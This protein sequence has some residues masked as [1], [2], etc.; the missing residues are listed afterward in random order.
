MQR[1]VTLFQISNTMS[2]L[3]MLLSSPRA[4]SARA[5]TG[6]RRPHSGVGKTFWRV[7][8][9]FFRKTT[10]TQKQKVEKLIPRCE[11]NCLS[12]GYKLAIDKIWGRM[13][14]NGFSGRKSGFQAKKKNVHFLRDTMFWPRPGKVVQTKKYPFPR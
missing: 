4:E 5:V 6:R 8:Q 11:M 9:V 2:P 1:K 10:V 3:L 12:K 14:K 7:D 13:A